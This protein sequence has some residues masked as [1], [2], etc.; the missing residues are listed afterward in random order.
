MTQKQTRRE[1][2]VRNNP[3]KAKRRKMW[4]RWSK[5]Y[6]SY[7]LT[8]MERSLVNQVISLQSMERSRPKWIFILQPGKDF[9]PKQLVIFQRNCGPQRTYTGADF[10]LMD[11]SPWKDPHQSKKKL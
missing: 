9:I 3:A 2:N 6:L 5:Q 1:K 8:L 7:S 4:W 11:S 10:F